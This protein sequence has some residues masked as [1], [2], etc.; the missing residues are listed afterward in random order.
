MVTLYT[1][2]LALNGVKVHLLLLE[3]G[4]PYEV[5]AVDLPNGEHLGAACREVN[6][7]G[8]LPFLRDEG[9]TLSESNAMLRYLAQ[10]WEL[11]DWFP[12]RLAERATVEQWMDFGAVHVNVPL[13][14]LFVARWWS[15]IFGWPTSLGNIQNALADLR[16]NLPLVEGRLAASPYLAGSRPT[17]ADLVVLPFLALTDA[18]GLRLATEHP[19]LAD[20]VARMTARPSW[21]A[22]S[23][24]DDPRWPHVRTP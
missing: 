8:R 24:L 23:A 13:G 14:H 7:S 22:V 21:V 19:R 11:E 18:I 9:L 10:K 12:T 3:S 1:H 20:W 5:R 17:L 4:R 15:R 16:R 2:P 6:P